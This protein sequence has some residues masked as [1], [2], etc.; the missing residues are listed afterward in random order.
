MLQVWAL[1]SGKQG[2]GSSCI[3][4]WGYDFQSL[5]LVDLIIIRK[6]Q[7]VT[8]LITVGL[9]LGFCGI[10]PGGAS[11]MPGTVHHGCYSPAPS[12]H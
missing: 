12:T 10:V 1:E 8:V 9:M 3:A 2:S 5:F 6:I 4:Y 7:I 11:R